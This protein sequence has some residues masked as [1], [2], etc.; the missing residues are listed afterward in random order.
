MF[1]RL[2]IIQ[3]IRQHTRLWTRSSDLCVAFLVLLQLT[4]D[5]KV[6]GP[7]LVRQNMTLS[8]KFRHQN[9]FTMLNFWDTAICVHFNAKMKIKVGD[10]KM[11]ADIDTI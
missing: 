2:Y 3:L 9:L 6:S 11:V 5:A 10:L 1:N 4:A 8:Q 7:D